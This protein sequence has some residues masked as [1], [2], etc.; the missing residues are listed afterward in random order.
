V[1]GR[2]RP[3]AIFSVS[4][5]GR[6]QF[7]QAYD[8]LAKDALRFMVDEF[9]EQ[10]VESFARQHVS[11]IEGRYL[12]LL[13]EGPPE[14]R[15]YALAEA[16]SADGYAASV[17]DAGGAVQMCQHHCP[18]AHVAADFPEL[19]EA[20]TDAFARLLGTHVQRL[21]TIA[22]GDGVCTTHIP[23]ASSTASDTTISGATT[24]SRTNTAS[25]TAAPLG[26]TNR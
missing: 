1:R 7:G 20:E 4:E 21:A 16:L 22:R 25:T 14:Q 2:G 18:I 9:G 19:C 24:A 3:A 10:A 13:P 26:R 15:A 5:R 17:T 11:T 12:P 8:L 23:H 6:E